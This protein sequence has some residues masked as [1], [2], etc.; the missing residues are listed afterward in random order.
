M[1]IYYVATTG[2]DSGAGTASSP[3][4]TIGRAMN[5]DLRP[6]D[7]VVVRAGTYR[8]AVTVDEGGSAAGH[9]TLRSETPG[10]AKI[11]A[12]SHGPNGINIV[13][14]YVTV[15]GF[16]VSGS[17]HHGI[18]GQHVHHVKVKD[19]ISH[20]NGASGIS[21]AWSEFM[22]IEGNVTHNN[23]SSGWY[24]GI[25][26]YQ[27][28]NI[29]GDTTTEGFR[30]IIRNNVSYENVTETGAHTDG[31]GIIID[32]YQSTQTSGHPNYTYPSLVENNLVY[33]NGGKGIQVT[34]SDNVTVRNNTA[35]HNNQDNLNSG[36]WRGELSNAQSSG[37]SWINNIAVADPTVNSN[38]RAIDNTSYG[39]YRNEDVVWVNNLTF[40]GQAGQ[41]S[42]R[43]DGNNPGPSAQNG[44]L[45]G[46]DPEF[47]NAP[48]NFELRPGSP[49]VD[50]GTSTYGLAATDLEGSAR[51]SGPVDLGAIELQWGDPGE[52]NA[53]PDAVDDHGFNGVEG[54]PTR[55]SVAD[56]L[57]NDSDPDGDSLVVSA[58]SNAFGGSAA[59]SEDGHVTFVPNGAAQAGF[60]YR[61]DD[62]RG[63][64][65]TAQ[66]RLSVESSP[67]T[68]A[69]GLWDKSA[70]PAIISDT[71]RSA[72]QLGVTF[73]SAVEGDVT[74]IQFYR[75]PQN[76]G[77]H[78]IRLWNPDGEIAAEARLAQTSAT[79]WVDVAFAEPVRIGAGEKW[80]ASY[81]APEG[82]Y[83][84]TEGYFDQAYSNNGLTVAQNGG[85]YVYGSA[86]TL[87]TNSYRASNYWIDVVF[88]PVEDGPAFNVISGT[89]GGER[90]R[91]TAEADQMLGGEGDD[92]LFGND[93]DDMLQGQSGNDLLFG[94]AG[95]DTLV[96]GTGRDVFRFTSAAQSP[97][98]TGRDSIVAGDGAIAFEGAGWSSLDVIDLSRIDAQK[99]VLGNQAFTFGSTDLGGLSVVDVGDDT[100][101]RGNINRDA[102]FEFEILIADAG[103]TA[104]SYGAGD[105][106]L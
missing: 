43:T 9:V 87:P 25:S 14:D 19:N 5:E 55:I 69:F 102:D 48:L 100:L 11:V 58:V 94:G 71:D 86:D 84:V 72:V 105:F 82:G 49:A 95:C 21:F 79:G 8:E 98:G 56:L 51:A 15:E 60:T 28:R 42:V 3:W 92:R 61:V 74:A 46:V 10:G 17:A 27:S 91:G 83:S 50:A 88:E 53:P 12:P 6:G 89:P 64:A 34:W 67:E 78:E 57:R 1:T 7:E 99:G 81:H 54:V 38:N 77:A 97:Q 66:V 80:I 37:N 20:D 4:K 33:L 68:D 26:V 90:L 75:G 22:E 70:V 13:A 93:G 96:G 30:T 16:D 45:L 32:D 76:A 29:T 73:S 2:S 23:A 65:D 24:S 62:G 36:T 59:L 35:W 101:V 40:N 18:N 41:A 104:S 85:V 63:G 103:V 31:N 52:P 47:L 106:I 39:G 44:N